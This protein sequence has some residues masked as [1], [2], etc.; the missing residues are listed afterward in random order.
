MENRDSLDRSSSE[1]ATSLHVANASLSGE[2][3]LQSNAGDLTVSE[4]S[5]P[6]ESAR[7]VDG[8]LQS[9]VRSVRQ[10]ILSMLILPIDWCQYTPHQIEAEYCVRTGKRSCKLMRPTPI[11]TKHPQDFASFLK[12]RSTLEEEHAQGLRKLCRSSHESSRRPDNRQGSYAQNY[13]EITRIH[14]RMVD[15]GVQF[16]LALHQMHEDLHDLAT[17][18]ERGR[19]QWKQTGLTAEKRV[20]DAEIAMDKAKTKYDSLAEDYD[21]AKT[22]DRQSGRVF[23]LKGP[24]S[25]AQ[26][27]E[28]L[29]RKVQAADSDYSS[30]VQAAQGLRRDLLATSRPQTVKALLD[31]INECD[32]GLTFQMQKFGMQPWQIPYHAIELLTKGLASL[33][34]KLLLGNGLC[35]SPLK[36]QIN[37]QA[38][39]P[40][41]LRDV[42]LQID[43]ERDLK[44][45]LLSFSSRAGPRHPDLSYQ[46]HP[47]GH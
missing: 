5:V 14:E 33:N 7:I 19:K 9:D 2:N 29:S 35:V 6:D 38:P 17:N 4:P 27:E 22:G 34:E 25:A 13:E 11:S 44:N 18:M 28:D 47:V 8:V 39:Q 1:V 16:A 37:G 10:F 41:S 20:Q 45:Y 40:R 21:R 32:S 31:L 42:V 12:K 15:N 24:K 36:A 3:E 43:N 23:G 46:R 26:V 30:K